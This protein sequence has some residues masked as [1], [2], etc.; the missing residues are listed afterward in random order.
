M[1]C[2]YLALGNLVLLVS[3]HHRDRLDPNLLHL[4]SLWSNKITR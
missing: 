3:V 2:S 4:I 1:S